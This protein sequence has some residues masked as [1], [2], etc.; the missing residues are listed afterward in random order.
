MNLTLRTL[1]AYLDDTL[2]PKDARLIGRKVAESEYAQELIEKIKKVT[3]RRGLV[4]SAA[5]NQ[6]AL[7]PN[8]VAEYLENSL[9]NDKVS[10]FEESCLESDLNLAEIASCHQILTLVEGEPAQVPPTARQRMYRLV[11]GREAIPYRK[12]PAPKPLPSIDDDIPP[13][14]ETISNLLFG[15]PGTGLKSAWYQRTGP[16]VMVAVLAIVLGFSIRQ[17]LP[18]SPPAASSSAIE[19]ADAS[20][21]ATTT[22]SATPKQP[23]PR[24]SPSTSPSTPA[25]K[26]SGQSPDL[27]Q[28]ER[29]EP[30]PAPKKEPE[31]T[32]PQDNKKTPEPPKEPIDKKEPA[33]QPKTPLVVQPVPPSNESKP[34]AFYGAND[35]TILLHKPDAMWV[36]VLPNQ[37][38]SSNVPL[39]GLPGFANEILTDSV[40][41]ILWGGL[42]EIALI[43]L[44][45]TRVTLHAPAN[46]IDV[47]LTLTV[48]RI[49]LQNLRN[50]GN[51]T[52][53][54]RMRGEL[55]ELVLHDP[56]TE[57]GVS[58][59]T[60]RDPNVRFRPDGKAQ[61]ARHDAYLCVLKGS[62]TVRVRNKE[63]VKLVPNAQIGWDSFT[64]KISEPISIKNEALAFWSKDYPANSYF[65]EALVEFDKRT[66]RVG[67]R[68]DV[69]F[70][71]PLSDERD[72]PANRA[73]AV[74]CM[75][76]IDALKNLLDAMSCEQFWEARA[77]GV[78]ATR[79]WAAQ[80]P[81]REKMLY[82]M[83]IS[84]KNMAP[85]EAQNVL[86][87]LFLAPD[88]I[89]I[90]T[91]D[92][93]LEFLNHRHLIIREIAYSHMM[94]LVDPEGGKTY[95]PTDPADV[96]AKK[97]AEW[98]KR[99]E[100]LKTAPS[101]TPMPP[102]N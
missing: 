90:D 92:S 46:G 75:E 96:R 67:D 83:L 44:L 31:I 101:P 78:Q 16:L 1:L 49:F 74:L 20:L 97:V 10:A 8:E 65:K 22:G 77:T 37:R 40:R 26:E 35:K 81:S 73:Y 71:A 32:T 17:A 88:Q 55:W 84:N 95:S 34:V 38:I 76:S 36:R 30:I 102:K 25:K 28:K 29:Q 14:S 63:W 58:Y 82:D 70:A 47:D 72:K 59:F 99:I 66:R 52:I 43:P 12:P 3:R 98:K 69:V 60:L 87:L 7:D 100:K 41:L 62:A 64:D 91:V 13:P 18:P 85:A 53:R 6:A 27:A 57:I 94:T 50:N 68:L 45:E 4:P 51:T 21:R 9:A 93:L 89:S 61:S 86:D 19:L 56:Q 42:P 79:V 11:Q 80:E 5:G 33:P 23:E 24:I 39:V 2:D 54:L 48:G 15:L